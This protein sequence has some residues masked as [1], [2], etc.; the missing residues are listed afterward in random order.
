MVAIDPAAPGKSG[1]ALLK[2]V[3]PAAWLAQ[4]EYDFSV[5]QFHNGRREDDRRAF[6]FGWHDGRPAVHMYDK[7]A[8]YLGAASSA[9][10]G[11]GAPEHVHQTPLLDQ[12]GIWHINV[13]AAPE[14]GPLP[15]LVETVRSWQYTPIVQLLISLGYKLSCDEAYLFPEQHQVLRPFYERVRALRLEAK[16]PEDISAIKRLYTVSFGILAH[17]RDGARPGYLYRPD[18]FF[19]LVAYSKAIMYNQMRRVYLKYGA[20]PSRVRVDALY[21]P[22][23]LPADALPLGVGIGQFKY[24]IVGNESGGRP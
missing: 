6:D 4:P 1:I 3:T 10:L 18:W 5:F 21:Y 16:T 8:M 20:A 22:D 24:K 9:R 15:P 13:I 14:N 2:A 7:S 23:A 12:P 11:V 19:G 17:A